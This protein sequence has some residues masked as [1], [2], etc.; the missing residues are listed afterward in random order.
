MSL[1]LLVPFTGG[2]VVTTMVA[3]TP[4]ILQTF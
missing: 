2:G 3:Q 4:L 1:G